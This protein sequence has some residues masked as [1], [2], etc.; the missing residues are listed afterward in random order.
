MTELKVL[1]QDGK[2]EGYLTLSEI[3]VDDEFRCREQEDKETIESYTEVFK[4][5][6]KKPTKEEVRLLTH[7]PDYRGENKIYPFPAATIW[8]TVH[9]FS[10]AIFVT[11]LLSRTYKNRSVV[12]L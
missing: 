7:C 9:G 10:G 4:E 2:S 11:C 8:V 1:W 5:Y 12:F 3:T 6:N